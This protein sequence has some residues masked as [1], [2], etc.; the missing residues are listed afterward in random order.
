MAINNTAGV[1]ANAP[2]AIKPAAN[3][4]IGEQP[5]ASDAVPVHQPPGERNR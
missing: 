1:V 5:Y 2:T 3:R 4:T